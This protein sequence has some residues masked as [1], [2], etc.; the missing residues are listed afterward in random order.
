M[1]LKNCVTNLLKAH[2]RITVV[3]ANVLTA[4]CCNKHVTSP[5]FNASCHIRASL[6]LHHNALLKFL[7][8]AVGHWC[9]PVEE[10]EESLLGTPG[11]DGAIEKLFL[12]IRDHL[13]MAQEASLTAEK[14]SRLGDSGE[15]YCHQCY[16]SYVTHSARKE[17]A[18]W[19][20][21][22][23]CIKFIECFRKRGNRWQALYFCSWRREIVV[24]ALKCSRKW[25]AEG[26]KKSIFHAP[27][28]WN[29]QFFVIEKNNFGSYCFN[30]SVVKLFQ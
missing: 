30:F 24:A 9:L 5:I 18:Y 15:N 11:H 21:F 29:L 20:T 8:E 23:C 28:Y 26:G 12:S 2:K 4:N 13:H 19:I 17:S 14:E 22:S 7:A 10:S 27:G 16:A 25:I 3:L 6:S 1:S